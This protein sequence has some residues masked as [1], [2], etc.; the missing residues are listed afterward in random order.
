M[1]GIIA[2]NKAWFEV[3]LRRQQD[4]VPSGIGEVAM[5]R[6]C[7]NDFFA[8][9]AEFEDDVFQLMCFVTDGAGNLPR[10]MDMYDLLHACATRPGPRG[11]IFA[12]KTFIIVPSHQAKLF[13]TS[14]KA[15]HSSKDYPDIA[16]VQLP[17]PWA[18]S[19]R[20]A[21]FKQP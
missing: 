16:I 17:A 3:L 20:I 21:G 19:G 7:T 11:R 8:S 4:W 5:D 1:P 18:L 12:A 10:P 13:R 14:G 2:D 9:S 15:V 6:Y